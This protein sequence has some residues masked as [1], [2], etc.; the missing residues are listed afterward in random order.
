M[1]LGQDY[2]KVV[3]PARNVSV[4]HGLECTDTTTIPYSIPTIQRSSPFNADY[5]I[6]AKC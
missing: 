4:S 1:G 2:C 6:H 3:G 5:R